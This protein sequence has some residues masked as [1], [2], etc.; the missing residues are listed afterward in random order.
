MPD[1]P[2]NYHEDAPLFRDAIRFTAAE[3]G[4]SERLIEKDYYC[5]VA[6]ADLTGSVTEHVFKGGTC[7]SKIHSDFYRLSEDLDFGISMP[8]DASRNQRSKRVDT[9]K[10]HLAGIEERLGVLRIIDPFRGFNNSMQYGGRLAYRSAVTG[11]DDYV[12]IEMSVR[13]PVIESP[14][15]LPA[16]TLL[17]DPFRGSHAV[18]AI[19][20]TVLTRRETYAEKLRA[21]L[22]RRDPA[23]RDFFDL[24]HAMSVAKVD[25]RDDKL[26]D[27][28]RQKLSI[29]G[30]EPVDMTAEKLELLRVQLETQ[31]KPVLR[32]E[33]YAAFD[34]DRAFECVA[35]LDLR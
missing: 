29:P 14:V 9:F 10:T 34:L 13:E 17:L 23:I 21:A 31:L 7:L 2:I 12:R 30:N 19:D 28:L 25:L 24:D 1:L 6:L 11:Q 32:S 3:T 22:S 20:V 15:R 35:E 27:L 5:T 26:L 18:L 8:V 4:F 16:R 33:D